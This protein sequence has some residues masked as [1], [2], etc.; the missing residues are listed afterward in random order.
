VR[1]TIFSTEETQ[2]LTRNTKGK[3][4]RI[5]PLGGDRRKN[6]AWNE[7]VVAQVGRKRRERNKD[8]EAASPQ[9]GEISASKK[10]K[11]RGLTSSE[12]QGPYVSK[13]VGEESLVAHIPKATGKRG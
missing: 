13:G 11:D 10:R 5:D 12:E 7:K 9:R 2:R 4:G 6:K 3:K 8:D 1:K